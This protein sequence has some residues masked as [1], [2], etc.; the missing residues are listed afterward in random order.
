MDNIAVKLDS[1]DQDSHDEQPESVDSQTDQVEE[2]ELT[3][4]NQPNDIDDSDE[5]LY[6]TIGDREISLKD[7]EEWEQGYLRQSDYTRK[8]QEVAKQRESVTAEL[9]SLKAEREALQKDI[10]L[11]KAMTEEETLSKEELQELREYEPEAYIKY[12]EKQAKRQELLSKYDK[13]AQQNDV[14]AEFNKVIERHSEWVE[15]GKH[16]DKFQSDV[17]AMREYLIKKGFN[18]DDL[19]LFKAR[20]FEV[21]LDAMKK[22]PVQ[23]KAVKKATVSIKPKKR[24]Q[25]SLQSQIQK[26]KE[27]LAKTGSVQDAIA[28]RKL[29]KQLEQ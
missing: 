8:N 29:R 22:E 26:A 23:N 25:S 14:N 5:E 20:H 21:V 18:D 16:T 2:S 3:D 12:T 17:A 27:R 11:L 1:S 19:S 4:D 13:P 7:I 6:V 9:E 15:N 10:A 24:E 28:L